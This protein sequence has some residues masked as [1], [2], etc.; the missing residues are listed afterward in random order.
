MS[1]CHSAQPKLWSVSWVQSHMSS[2][3]LPLIRALPILS[4]DA[5]S[6]GLHF[7]SDAPVF[8]RLSCGQMRPQVAELFVSCGR[9]KVLPASDSSSENTSMSPPAP[10]P[11]H[12]QSSESPAS[13]AHLL[14]SPSRL[15]WAVLGQAGAHVFLLN[16]IFPSGH[17]AACCLRQLK[18]LTCRFDLW[19]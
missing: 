4:P 14:L 13:L 16:A 18:I 3:S 6:P 2:A 15:V 9:A 11:H 7:A 19:L 1:S 12:Q 5:R 10:P 8:P 17:T